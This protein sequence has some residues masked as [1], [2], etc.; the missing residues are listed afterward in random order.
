MICSHC[1]PHTDEIRSRLLYYQVVFLN[2]TFVVPNEV[3]NYRKTTKNLAVANECAMF[4]TIV[5]T[6]NAL[7]NIEKYVQSECRYDIFH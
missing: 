7:F 4:K 2:F 6:R 3:A 1:K 5:A